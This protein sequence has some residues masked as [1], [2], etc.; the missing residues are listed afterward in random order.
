MIKN[1]QVD[2]INFNQYQEIIPWKSIIFINI[3]ILIFFFFNI[4]KSQAVCSTSTTE[5]VCP[6][7]IALITPNQV[8]E[9]DTS[10]QAIACSATPY[11]STISITLFSEDRSEIICPQ[12]AFLAAGY[13]WVGISMK[14]VDDF[15]ADGPIELTLSA[16]FDG[17][18][19]FAQITVNDNDNFSDESLE[20][21]AL[22][23]LYNSTSG[24]SWKNH[25]GWQT[26]D[27]N[28][29]AWHGIEC[30]NGVMPVS[31]IRLNDQNLNGLL[32][33]SIGKFKDLK[34]LFLGQ[35]QLSGT[36]PESIQNTRLHTL[37]LQGNSLSG[38]IPNALCELTF[39]QEL[40]LSN[41]TLNG[42]LPS[43][44]S[45]L[46]RISKLNLS[47]NQ[48][49]GA[50]PQSFSQLEKLAVL[51]LHDNAFSGA[52]D[53]LS[54][55]C[56][57]K[58]LDISNNQFNSKLSNA[59]L[60]T[61]PVLR[62]LN[63]YTNEFTGNFPYSMAQNTL[64][65]RIDIHD[66]QLSGSLPQW[67]STGYQLNTLNLKSNN[68]QGEIPETI[69]RLTRLSPGKL[70]LRWNAL[71][72][73]SQAVKNFI[74]ARHVGTDWETTQTIAPS[75]ITATVLSAHAIR[76]DWTPIVFN[77]NS[78]AYEIHSS[79]SLDLSFIKIAE[80]ANKTE[81]SCTVTDLKSSKDYYF[82]IRSRTDAHENNRNIV[83]SEFSST[84]LLKTQSTVLTI[85]GENGQISPSGLVSVP[86][87][88]AIV[89]SIIPDYGFHVSDVHIDNKSVGPVSSYTFTSVLYPRRIQ[90]YFG[91]DSPQL[92]PIDP[93]IFDEDIAPPP[94]SL[95]IT[96]RES[97]LNDLKITVTSANIELIPENHIFISGNEST[98]KLHLKPAAE[99]SGFGI[100]SVNVS[101]PQGLSTT[102]AFP[103]TVNIINDPPIVKNLIYTA[104]EDKEIDCLF[105]GLDIEEDDMF[106]KIT[107]MP[108]HGDLTHAL[109]DNSF[110]YRADPDY[111]GRDYIKYKAQDRSSLGPKMSG[112]ATIIMNILP[113]ND[114]P[115]A[116]AGEDIYTSEG[117]LVILD[118]SKSSDVDMDAI[119][120]FWTQTYGPSVELSSPQAISPVFIAPHSQSDGS[121]LSLIFWLT[122][123]DDVGTS[124]Y[125]D[126]VVWVKPKDPKILPFAQ[127]AS[128]LSPVS[129]IAPM[130]VKFIDYS[131]GEISQWQ[132]SFGDTRTSSR[133]HPVYTYDQPGSYT[134]HLLITGAG[135]SDMI[136]KT[137]WI[138]VLPNPDAIT[139]SIQANE[140]DALVDLYNNTG[141]NQW[142]WKTNWLDPSG[143]EHLWYGV[144]VPPE[145][146]H[147]TELKL[148]NNRLDGILPSNLNQLLY[149]EQ[150]DLSKNNIQ[151]ALPDNI[152]ELTSL[153]RLN[154]SHNKIKG[155]LSGKFHRLKQLTHLILTNNQ[156]YG[157]IP[158]TISQLNYLKELYLNQN[159][160]IGAVPQSFANLTALL[161]LSLSFNK[162][163][164]PLPDFI[165]QM[166][167]LQR[168]DLSHNQF[169]GNIPES[170]MRAKQL[171]SLRLANNQINGP[172][173]EGFEN[174]KEL[175]ELDLSFNQIIGPITDT[176]YESPQLMLLNLSHN[177]LDGPLKTRIAL[178][179][180]LTHLNL[181]Y[182]NFTGFLP[183]E[184]TRLF[185]L[186]HLNIS[187]N[188]FAGKVPDLITKLNQL[189]ILDLSHNHF[190]GSFPEYFLQLSTIESINIAGNDFYG[191]I[192]NEIRNMTWLKDSAS[193]F[194]W[195]RLS[196]SS[197]TIEK[198]VSSKQVS[199]ETW[200]DTQTIAPTGLSSKEGDSFRELI[201]S[202]EP[203]AYTADNG[204][205][206]IYMASDVD[207]PYERRY[208]THSKMETSYTV[209][210][211]AV[212]NTYYFIIRTVTYPHANN[213]NTL[214]SED[215]EILAVT[216]YELITRPKEP[217]SITLESYYENRVM[218]TWSKQTN[219]ADIYYHVYRNETQDGIFQRITKEPLLEST[220]IDYDVHPGKDYYYKVRSYTGVTPS[221]FFSEIVHAVP[222]APTTY[223][224][225]G[226]FTQAVI[227]QGETT[228]Y[229]LTLTAAD[230]FTGKIDIEC[231]WPGADPRVWPTGI[232]Q[233]FYLNGY[234]MDTKLKSIPLPA[235]IGLKLSTAQNY[236]P[237]VLFFQMQFTDSKTKIPRIF[238][239]ELHI[240][241][242]NDCGIILSTD[243]PFYDSWSDIGIS[244]FI[245]KRFSGEPVDIKY[246]EGN[247]ILMQSSVLTASD[248]SFE[249]FL[250]PQALTP[251][252]YTITATWT[253]WNEDQIFCPDTNCSVAKP[254]TIVYEATRFFLNMNDNQTLPRVGTKLKLA[255][256][257]SPY[258][259]NTEVAIRIHAPDENYTDIIMDNVFPTNF[260]ISDILLSQKGLW[261]IKGY[262]LS[263][264]TYRNCE[265]EFFEILVETPP[266]RAIILGSSYPEY[267]TQLPYTTH[268]ICK[269]VYDQL[270]QRSFDPI[271]I[272][273]MMHL[274]EDN[275]LDPPVPPNEQM[276]WIDKLNPTS[277][278]F[279][280]ALKNE[281][282]DVLH[283]YLPLW[284]FIHGF[285]D[286]KAQIRMAGSY[287]LL[288]VQQ[289]DSALDV[290][291]AAS[292]CPV[293]IIIDTPYSGAFIQ[294]LTGNDRII[295]TSTESSNYAVDSDSDINFSLRF[296]EHLNGGKNVYQSFINAKNSWD[297][298]SKA[299]AQME[300]NGD[301]II[302]DKDRPK[303][304]QQFMNGP[305]I[306][307][308]PPVIENV[309]IS[310]ELQYATSLP[311]SVNIAAGTN[312]IDR[313]KLKLLSPAPHP[314]YKDIS[315]STDYVTYD[316]L[317]TSQ[318]GNYTGLLTCLT[319]PGT[320]TLLVV[321]ED[322]HQYRSEPFCLTVVANPETPVSY[323]E[324]V[325]DSTRHTL[326]ALCGFFT[327]SDP[328]FH[329][330]TT[331]TDKSLRGVW[332]LNHQHVF[333][334]G[335]GGIILKFDGSQWQYMESYTQERL[336]A[337][338]GNAADNVYAVGENGVM[339]HFNG[340]IWEAVD[341]QIQNPLTGIWGTSDNN[342]FAVGGHGTIL[343][344]DGKAWTR[345]YTQWY[346]R[347]NDIWGRNASD[348]YAAGENG[349][350]LHFDG[351]AWDVLPFCFQMPVDIIV[352]DET[353]V[354]SLHFFDPII[355]D[356]GKG[357]TPTQIC[358]Y[359]EMNDS[360]QNV[361]GHV[362]TVGEKGRTL[363]W[364]PPPSCETQNT[365]PTISPI[366]NRD[367]AIYQPVPPIPFTVKDAE[368]FP[369]ELVLSVLSSNP[370]LVN[371]DQVSIQGTGADRFLIVT[372]KFGTIGQTYLSIV[373]E[374]PCGSKQADGFLL[375]IYENYGQSNNGPEISGDFDQNGV[376][377]LEDIL[378][379]LRML[380]E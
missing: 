313:V 82:K 176:L 271:E 56:E 152:T 45:N 55:L 11:T 355:F 99:M 235:Q 107:A 194:R 222:G 301:G 203:I 88:K 269:Q 246:W 170:L 28:P 115:F 219:P 306:Q 323:F 78:G 328:N 327:T 114:A 27:I 192:P 92:L 17:I 60:S 296:F 347:L 256:N 274:P 211:L 217:K 371:S 145:I 376:I 273:T 62:I 214:Y 93:I 372:P 184:L 280:D 243:K 281:F 42:N 292:K 359:S 135:G 187:H 118:G 24:D 174:Y 319:L 34:R 138:T 378:E 223:A 113:V 254:I 236:T 368:S 158:E 76:F 379:V 19:T 200:V 276:D 173:P 91:N 258:S 207:G 349:I 366:S 267:Q 140:R 380:G 333:A 131:I 265:S 191:L 98:K 303:A 298:F 2:I 124:A 103:Y 166:I 304:V 83:Y 58:Q 20:K 180:Q 364:S 316:L 354:F 46:K 48:L 7:K 343:H 326:D 31:E 275:P 104:Y 339:R 112:E 185:R 250:P 363:I 95:S 186:I 209:T 165:D 224:I 164:G 128:P 153:T 237:S 324:N 6:D 40:N 325:T 39:L 9:S 75:G 136:S 151:A 86:Q 73:N 163:E 260:E 249:T 52:V 137:N 22:S 332:G 77:T 293:I 284:L 97:L 206:E 132:W 261:K 23:D 221:N 12:T 16:E 53:L 329:M 15:I 126:C 125:D 228:F 342:I 360:W 199:G 49:S 59:Q 147:V 85:A 215:T 148:S 373:V 282:Q 253:V 69:V 149:L 245:S 370:N 5:I 213:P 175:Q 346:D 310:K 230:G 182:N 79:P 231:L 54:E 285:A 150:I 204:G 286:S 4:P 270:I 36:I 171:R 35:N 43:N 70:D 335:D 25:S 208:V 229:S 68:L 300:T 367:I 369:Y 121:P 288:T 41:N 190:R 188:G 195:N 232:D 345:Q 162:L 117:E 196:V 361:G 177:Q 106:Y 168:L 111:F 294:H 183:I 201:L 226:H 375:K 307:I 179:N 242:Q 172:I 259:S 225:D 197:R 10:F 216:V 365:P 272:L 116:K 89:F 139:P 248:G 289:I 130:E 352:G 198:F 146:P 178:L 8:V 241:S 212:N 167:S 102:Q 18:T 262:L 159:Q 122:V 205:Y 57:L 318:P 129:G 37:W 65:L 21:Q 315:T 161:D 244:G 305:T 202:W 14:V 233:M 321:A 295:I 299:S 336:L 377:G 374:D 218:L 338:W 47:Q 356:Q 61:L 278:I 156:F 87:N 84:I 142:L 220:F 340:I 154:V 264:E 247:K 94:I 362:F 297:N 81:R 320:Y 1:K 100:I 160:L 66:T 181:S 157:S 101:D 334:V 252:N 291:Q 302:N 3:L 266:G 350:M 312:P 311:V 51:D 331:P 44:I 133:Q 309:S 240:I 64:L 50:L 227:A 74:D 330:V 210:G 155:A 341:T 96:D 169:S 239:M 290:L 143:N 63:L 308:S 67:E 109:E 127:I 348:I 189:T 123:T 344:Y 263:G 337:V 144:T 251:D 283:P 277:E 38:K 71:Y 32:P 29:C 357:W 353:N 108:N 33:A 90:A 317:P 279:I 287:D 314:L 110:L 268:K 193:D 30:D 257:I 119:K 234:K 80:T 358:N 105:M 26:N 134:V 351:N 322:R 255:G 120:F 72:S 238:D 141:G 13:T